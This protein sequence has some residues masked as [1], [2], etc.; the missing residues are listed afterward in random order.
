M[1]TS[2]LA[3][4]ETACRA[5]GL[6]VTGPRR[7]IA[8]VL[9]EAHDHPDV[10][11]LH[12]RAAARDARISL[13]TVYRTV[14]MFEDIGVIERHAFNDGR[15]RYER[16]PTEHHD[17]LIDV[18]SGKVIEFHSEEIEE[19]Q[20]QIAAKLGYRIVGHRLELYV[21]PLPKKSAGA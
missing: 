1:P 19:L 20:A 4:I 6:R 21:E 15:A 13:A 12:R 9:S 17:H 2:R 3:A 16:T 8:Q 14:K 5:K 18:K 11:E 10:T 7:V